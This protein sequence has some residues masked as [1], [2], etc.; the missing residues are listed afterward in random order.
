MLIDTHAHLEFEPLV[1]EID[2]VIKR[3]EEND[4]QKIITLGVSIARAE[5]AIKIAEK[6]DNIYA[7]IGIHP[8]DVKAHDL[9]NAMEK[10]EEM[11]RTSKK[12]VAIGETGLD[13]YRVETKDRK[14][15]EELQKTFFEAHIALAKK[16][17]LP[18]IVH[19][20]HEDT[21]EHAYEI[22]KKH[23]PL[24]AVI[25]CYSG[26]YEFAE[27]LFELGIM[28]SITG[29]VTFKNAKE[30]QGVVE[31]TPLK[32]MM[33]ETDA[34]YLAPVPH[35]G[36]TNEPAYVKHVAEKIAKIKNLTL[37]KVA[38]ETTKNA[39]HFFGI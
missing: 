6:Y 1:N 19:L 23:T 35:R 3:A 39:E 33:I 18:V 21:Y 7:A 38:R 30:L 20:R 17:N 29:I 14:K 26:T 10:F 24:K 15:E 34:P 32:H 11:I 37:Q 8:D 28:I 9:H 36:R 4:V 2:K 25:H 5:K 31:K 12:I 13:Y 22:L 27:R 16:Y